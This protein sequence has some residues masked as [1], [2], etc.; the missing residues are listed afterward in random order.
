MAVTIFKKKSTGLNSLFWDVS[1]CFPWFMLPPTK[2]KNLIQKIN[3]V[4]FQIT[5]RRWMD[6]WTFTRLHKDIVI[7]QVKHYTNI[8]IC[9]QVCF[10]FLKSKCKKC[11]SD[12]TLLLQE[13]NEGD[14][15]KLKNNRKIMFTVHHICE[16]LASTV[17]QC[18]K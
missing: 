16:H 4:Y 2:K 3:R 10:V 7:L 6:E 14:I 8:I 17:S 9:K 13:T 12:L 18:L 1:T 5:G 11:M 15:R